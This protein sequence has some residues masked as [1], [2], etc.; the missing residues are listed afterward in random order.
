MNNPYKSL[1]DHAF[2]K[3]G[4]E[5]SDIVFPKKI[6]NPKWKINDTDKI[7]TMGSCF[8]QH[9]AKWLRENG[10]NVPFYETEGFK[11]SEQTFSANY[12]N[13]YTVKQALQLVE[14]CVGKRKPSE[15]AWNSGENFIDAL[16][17]NSTEGGF[18][19]AEEVLRS[20]KLHL[21][22]VREMV[23]DFDVLIFT[24]GLT[25]AWG[26][27][28]CGTIVPTAPGV[29]GGSFDQEKYGFLNLTYNDIL[30]D[31]YSFCRLLE[32]IRDNKP[33]RILLTVSP[34]PLTATATDQ[35]VL[36]ASTYSK[37]VLRSVAGD[38]SA[39]NYFAE[40]FPSFEIINNPAARSEFF[41]NNLRSVKPSAV[42]NVMNVFSLLALENPRSGKIGANKEL[43]PLDPQCE[44]ALLEEFS[45]NINSG[46]MANKKAV[47]IVGVGTSHLVGLREAMP[48]D[49]R[50]TSYFFPTNWGKYY[51]SEFDKNNY[52][53][54]FL[55]REEYKH[56]VDDFIIQYYDTLILIGLGL[57][58]DEI[59]RCHGRMGR[60]FSPSMPI[61]NIVDRELIDFYKSFVGPRM[62]LV[63]LLDANSPYKKIFWVF[64]PDMCVDVAKF[65][66]GE[67]FVNSG[68]YLTHKEAYLKSFKEC[69]HDFNKVEF[70]HHD[71]S[72]CNS[73]NGFTLNKYMASDNPLDIHC[74]SQYYEFAAA[75][76][77]DEIS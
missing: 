46:N 21:N 74:N 64:G 42:E 48:P 60:D 9:I 77:F 26:I 45:K 33:F 62:E 54:H 40:Y 4:V 19:T 10:F 39:D 37:S 35:H 34:V 57:G 1:N 67:E 72:L 53:T 58:G 41:E 5:N 22:S 25:E 66:L 68:S 2:W 13:I 70:I 38:F 7:A 17:P 61:K 56:L 51:W 30:K 20:R 76:I 11:E 27:K 24:L 23:K 36:L 6:Y 47:D 14:E 31:L 69:F 28:K 16:R 43:E 65:R 12:G 8:A 18:N 29:L 44:D 50:K 73:D 55:V 63:K 3:N 52:L 59:I 15:V 75:R 71:N 32:T 49:S